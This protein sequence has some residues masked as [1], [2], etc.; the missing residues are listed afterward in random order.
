MHAWEREVSDHSTNRSACIVGQGPAVS[1]KAHTSG[2][3]GNLTGMGA[4]RYV[5]TK[6]QQC[7]G[8]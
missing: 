1:N 4:L 6:V 2:S 7:T 8:R 3:G 5:K